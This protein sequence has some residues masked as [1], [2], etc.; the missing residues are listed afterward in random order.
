MLADPALFAP[1]K[2]ASQR[3]PASPMH[4]AERSRHW[5]FPMLCDS[6]N[7]L[8]AAKILN[9]RV[10]PFFDEHDVLLPRVLTDRGTEYCGNRETHEYQLYLAVENI[11]T[12]TGAKSPQTNGICGRFHRTVQEEFYSTA[13]RKKLYASQDQ[14]QADLDEAARIQSR[15]P[16]SGKCCYGKTPMQTFLNSRRLAH[17]NM[18]D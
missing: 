13:V 15:A 2:S 4:G 17:D 12:R 18:L 9:H 1:D 3:D 16:H 8:L 6:K 10:L 5:R 7:A 14:I 11:D